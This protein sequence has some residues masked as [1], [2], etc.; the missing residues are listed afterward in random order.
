VEEL[1]MLEP[2]TFASVASPEDM[3][4]I[5]ATL[6]EKLKTTKVKKRALEDIT[7]RKAPARLRAHSLLS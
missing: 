5:L 3:A 6:V 1:Q 7:K 4:Q 2:P